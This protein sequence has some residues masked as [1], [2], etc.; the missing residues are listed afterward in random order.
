MR[1]IV[2]ASVVLCMSFLIIPNSL[3]WN[4]LKVSMKKELN[5]CCVE[6]LFITMFYVISLLVIFEINVKINK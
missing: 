4:V 3:K 1:K 2:Q 6:I 5:T